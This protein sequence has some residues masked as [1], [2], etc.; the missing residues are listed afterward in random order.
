MLKLFKTILKAGE[1]TVK[2][3]FAPLPV[4]D[5]FRGKPAYN[6]EQCIACAACTTACPANALTMSTD[7]GTGTRTW[8]FFVG[9]CI[10]CGRCE[11]VCPTKAIVL[12]KEFEMAVANAADMYEHATFKLAKCSVCEDYFAPQKEI[13]YTIGLL[14]QTG[15]SADA[16]E[17]RSDQLH[18]CVDCKRKQSVPG[19]DKVELTR[20]LKGNEA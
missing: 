19:A 8:S 13:E 6:P 4:C 20:F 9:R 17:S 2:Y 15:M 5:N 3:P 11:E 16:V 12:S 18:T 10:F 1:A 14:K 7:T